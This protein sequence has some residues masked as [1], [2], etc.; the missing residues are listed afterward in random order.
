[1]TAALIGLAILLVIVLAGVPL[2]FA[3]ALVGLGGLTFILGFEPA[4]G[5]L[6]RVALDTVSEYTFSVLPLFLLM[7]NFTAR[8]GLA[9][10]LYA[11]SYAFIGHRRG[12]LAMS[13]ILACGGFSTVSGSSLATAATM[14]PIAMPEMRTAGMR[15]ACQ[16][17]R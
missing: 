4:I 6:A 7:A 9:A 2:A 15:P 14:A 17:A 3:M 8:S 5:Q 12:G 10:E 11:A 13:T 16:Q 1:M